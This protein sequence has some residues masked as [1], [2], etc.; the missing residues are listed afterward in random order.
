MPNTAVAYPLENLVGWE[1]SM[2]AFLVKKERR[3]GSRMSM[4]TA[5][6]RVTGAQ[7]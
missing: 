3:S 7:E 2:V 6:A 4:V 5:C 1:R